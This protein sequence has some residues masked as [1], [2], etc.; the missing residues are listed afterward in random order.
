MR[1]QLVKAQLATVV[2]KWCGS[3]PNNACTVGIGA[4]RNNACTVGIG[5]IRNNG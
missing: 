4:I 5:A 2:N 1:V 3:I